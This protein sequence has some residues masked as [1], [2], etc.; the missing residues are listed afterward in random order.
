MTLSIHVPRAHRGG[1]VGRRSLLKEG[2][3]GM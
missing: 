1:M 2:V 3:S